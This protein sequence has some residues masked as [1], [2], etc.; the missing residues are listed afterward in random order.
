[1][2]KTGRNDPCPCGSGKKYKKCC[3]PK[4]EVRKVNSFLQRRT[5][6]ASVDSLRNKIMRFVEKQNLKNHLPEA[7][8]QY[9][10]SAANEFDDLGLDEK[11]FFGFMEWFIHDFI[12]SDYGTP[13]IAAYLKS[14]PNLS[15]KERQILE[16]WQQTNLSVYQVTDIEE[17]HGIH[18]E[19]IFTGEK[20]FFHD[21]SLSHSLRKWELVICRKVWVL[22]EWQVSAAATRLMPGDKQ[23]IHSFVMAHYKDYLTDRPETTISEFLRRKGYLLHHFVINKEMETP[24]IPKLMTSHGEEVLCYEA[25]Y[26]VVDH[27]HVI[28]VLSKVA[29]YEI[30]K[31]IENSK[32]EVVE[33]TFDWLQRGGSAHLFADEVPTEGFCVSSFFTGGPGQE[34]HLLLGS[35]KVTPRRLK[36]S[37]TGKKRFKTGK[38]VL[39]T[40][41]G[42]AIRHRMDSL[43]TLDSK[44]SK[45]T[46][47]DPESKKIDPE[48][49]RQIL[50]DMFDDHFHKWLDMQI[51]ALGNKTPR[52]ASKSEQGRKELED[53]LRML[54]H[55]ERLRVERGE[56]EYDVSWIRRELNM[57]KG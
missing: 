35:V 41:L 24:I 23:E 52:E 15:P 21:V 37:V 7:M 50:Q 14:N 5:A 39:E 40:N 43:E 44:L 9:C 54:E 19:D 57:G 46:R 8:A 47:G 17:A 11:E 32:G 30:V 12:V 53:L 56:P 36:L 33:Y 49:E 22:D 25:L 18:V 26:D 42:Q 16:D 45:G 4:D 6:E 10:G 31:T 13:P 34:R 29:D 1:M 28:K 48:V 27:S 20:F 38:K 3:L 51:P 55:N 2:N